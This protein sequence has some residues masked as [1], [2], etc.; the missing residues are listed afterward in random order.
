M[1]ALAADIEK[2]LKKVAEGIAIVEDMWDTV[3]RKQG[4]F[5]VG[6]PRVCWYCTCRNAISG[7]S[8]ATETGA[9]CHSQ[10][11]HC[12]LRGLECL[13]L[14]YNA[15]RRESVF[16]RPLSRRCRCLPLIWPIQVDEA[17]SQALREKH[18]AELKKEIKRLQR[19]RENLKTWAASGEVKQKQP[20]LDAKK[21]IEKKMEA[22][23][24]LERTTKT[25]AYSRQG[26]MMA[27]E[28]DPEAKAKKDAREFLTNTVQQ[29]TEQ[30]DEMEAE[31]EADET[32]RRTGSA[33]AGMLRETVSNHQFHIEK[34]EQLTRLLDNDDITHERVMILSDDLSYYLE[35]N[36]EEDFFPDLEV[37]DQFDELTEA[38]DG[39]AEA[40]AELERAEAAERERKEEEEAKAKK[41]K[42]RVKQ[43]KVT[44]LAP[45]VVAT[46]SAS[47]A[48]SAKGTGI[49]RK[50]AAASAASAVAVEAGAASP[51]PAPGGSAV[52]KVRPPPGMAG[53]ASMASIVKGTA[54]TTATAASAAP[55]ASAASPLAVAASARK[56]AGAA[57][58]YGAAVAAASSADAD[59]RGA[60]ASGGSIVAITGAAL[61]AAMPLPQ[62]MALPTPVARPASA[63]VL[64]TAA[65]VAGFTANP[66][67]EVLAAGAA[68]PDEGGDAEPSAAAIAATLFRAHGAPAASADGV[69]RVS[70]GLGASL[71]MGDAAAD[72]DLDESS[73]AATAMSW[74]LDPDE[75]DLPALSDPAG[76]VEIITRSLAHIP[77]Y[78][79]IDRG[80]VF[81]PRYPVPAEHLPA[82]FPHLSVARLDDAA[83][84][85]KLS[86]DTLFFAFYFMQGTHH[87]ALAAKQLHASSWRLH[88]EYGAWFQRFKGERNKSDTSEVGPCKYFDYEDTWTERI[89]PKFE[90]RYDALQSSV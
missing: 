83:L 46:A 33:E 9:G 4:C 17:E 67:A 90:F 55:A 8:F 27:G 1:T 30:I 85:E 14:D 70:A 38:A 16:A 56:D 66:V 78:A 24:V 25:K 26:L 65:A 19:L 64:V 6:W 40:K 75:D 3:S 62:A 36:R 79:D 21:A 41:A 72:P 29:L 63:Q 39:A 50:G 11:D 71:F 73:V 81:V 58:V 49:S 7:T 68:M 10:R 61:P 22:F 12:D 28:L 86:P 48:A 52:P 82:A 34:L 37:Y 20:L 69:V 45:T 84:F 5:Q 74:L 59:S 42:S 89:L 88:R 53:G 51:A 47:S 76:A 60:A 13:Q 32:K 35:S 23:K 15:A 18:E 43:A 54:V 77:G 87:Q 44:V 57:A 2:T 31:I 80:R